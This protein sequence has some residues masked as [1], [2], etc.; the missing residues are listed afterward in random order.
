MNY[1]SRD[2]AV[3]IVVDAVVAIMIIIIHDNYVNVYWSSCHNKHLVFICI[4]MV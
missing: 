4:Y 1:T 3:V 2:V